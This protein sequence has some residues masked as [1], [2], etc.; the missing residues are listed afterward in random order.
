MNEI[1]LPLNIY[2]IWKNKIDE[3]RTR[4]ELMMCCGEKY[5]VVEIFNGFGLACHRKK[6]DSRVN[7]YIRGL[8]WV[9]VCL[10]LQGPFL[11]HC[12][13]IRVRVT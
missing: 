4:R 6:G 12:L 8:A 1:F 7:G 5:T 2:F 11:L 10:T 13:Y 9:N 3:K